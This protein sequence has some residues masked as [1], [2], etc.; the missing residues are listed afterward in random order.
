MEV[1]TGISELE[2][3]QHKQ[4]KRLGQYINDNRTNQRRP[5]TR[6]CFEFVLAYLVVYNPTQ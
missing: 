5:K 3:G 6:G 4:E 2:R 1:S